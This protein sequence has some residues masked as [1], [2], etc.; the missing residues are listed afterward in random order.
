MFY[1]SKI[2]KFD[3]IIYDI[4]NKKRYIFMIKKDNIIILVYRNKKKNFL[5]T[6]FTTLISLIA[7]LIF[8]IK[9]LIANSSI[10]L[11]NVEL[12]FFI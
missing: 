11:L 5:K 9:S 2:I 8:F 10:F 7:K 4:M 3:L 12:S 1:N 6:I